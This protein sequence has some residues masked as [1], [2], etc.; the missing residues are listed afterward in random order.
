MLLLKN[1]YLQIYQQLFL[2]LITILRITKVSDDNGAGTIANLAIAKALRNYDLDFN[3]LFVA[4][5][6]EEKGLLGSKAYVNKLAKENK[7]SNIAAVIN[8]E[9]LGYDSDNDGAVM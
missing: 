2:A 3:V 8:I 5:D 4:F 1:K 9:M 7:L 6:L